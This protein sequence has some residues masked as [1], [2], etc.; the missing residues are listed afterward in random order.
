MKFC[1]V[2]ALMLALAVAGCA[3]DREKIVFSDDNQPKHI[4]HGRRLRE[5]LE[6]P[7]T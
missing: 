2:P 6:P 4:N 7:Q 1:F 3:T 5:G